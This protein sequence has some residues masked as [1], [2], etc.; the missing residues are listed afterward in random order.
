M[1]L[2]SAFVHTKQ[3][4]SMRSFQLKEA[5]RAWFSY[6]KSYF[7]Y[8]FFIMAQYIDFSLPDGKRERSPKAMPTH[9]M[10]WHPIRCQFHTGPQDASS[11]FA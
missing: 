4:Y 8:Y 7:F 1:Q 3:I 5:E 6:N 10:P 11:R 2:N 9:K